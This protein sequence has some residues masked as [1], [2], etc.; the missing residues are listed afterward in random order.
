MEIEQIK[1]ESY[2]WGSPI[3]MIRKMVL[4]KGHELIDDGSKS[5]VIEY[6]DIILDKEVN[7]R[8]YFV[9]ELQKLYLI[10]LRWHDTSI[11]EALSGILTSKYGDPKLLDEESGWYRWERNRH[12]LEIRFDYFKGRGVGFGEVRLYYRSDYY[13]FVHKGKLAEI[14]YGE[15]ANRF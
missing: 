1:F 10:Y 5:G 3:D 8:L 11:Y 9:L 13:H 15:D 14:K 6:V 12:S 2:R 4:A 7:I